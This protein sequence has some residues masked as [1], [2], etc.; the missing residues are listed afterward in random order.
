MKY[1]LFSLLALTILFFVTSCNKKKET[2]QML[3]TPELISFE[4]KSSS[5]QDILD[6]DVQGLIMDDISAVVVRIPYQISGKILAPSV[7]FSGNDV[8]I[9][10][11]SIVNGTKYFDFNTPHSLTVYSETGDT[12]DYMVYVIAGA[13]L[14]TIRIDT[15]NR[16]PVDSREEKVKCVISVTGNEDFPSEYQITDASGTIKGR[17]NS[18]WYNPKKPYKIKFDEKQSVLGMP[19]DK[20]WV[21]LANYIDKTSIRN[22]L[23]FYIGQGSNLD[24]TCRSRFVELVLNDEFMGLYQ[25]CEQIKVATDRVNLSDDGFLLEIDKRA[26]DDGTSVYFDVP[27]MGPVVIK[28][29]DVDYNS[30][31]FEFIMSYVGNVS[32][33]LFSNAFLDPDNGYRSLLDVESFIDW[34]IINEIARNNDAVF[35]SS[36]YMNYDVGGKLKMGP[37]W[38]F[39]LAFG[40]VDTNDNWKIEGLNIFKIDWFSR[41]MKDSAFVQEVKVRYKFFYAHKS[42]YLAKIDSQ[43][44]YLI[45][46]I[47]EDN[48]KWGTL[49]AEP[50]PN[51]EVQ[52]CYY[53]EVLFLRNWLSDRMDWLNTYFESL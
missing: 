17:G 36:C 53:K 30:T 52:G 13:T 48:N 10:G 44:E 6:S 8:Q 1:F 26:P 29:P 38:D 41:L 20:E 28:D 40:N 18:T 49:Y 31:Q 12:R 7:T 4:F 50:W 51:S 23:A 45:F 22:V 24:Y 27:H 19:A 34:A 9:D 46:S 21:L 5:N 14:P 35:F 16:K 15:E 2:E 25:L 47:V 32:A 43:A 11:I 3:Q 42:D 37:L 39:D 33:V